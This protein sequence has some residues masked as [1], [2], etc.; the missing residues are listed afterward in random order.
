MARVSARDYRSWSFGDR[1]FLFAVTISVLWHL[2]WFFSVAITVAQP[3]AKKPG[4]TRVV[5]LGPVLDDSIFRTLIETRPEFSKA[6]YRELSDFETATE[7]PAQSVER[8]ESGDVTSLPVG[9][10][11]TRSLRALLGGDKSLPGLP[12]V[13]SDLRSGGDYFQ[14]TGDLSPGD[15][16]S[17]PAL[18]AIVSLAPV[19]IEFEVNSSG[20]VTASE[21]VLSSGDDGTDRRWEDHLRQWIFSPAAVLGSGG[22]VKAKAR[23]MR[24]EAL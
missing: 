7:L 17:R 23:F 18:P 20:K 2:F 6:F 8:H 12:P 22:V 21:I 11:F 14:L 16:L 4:E 15:V 3:K 19:E 24:P 9:E 1:Q 10:N 13:S 5:S